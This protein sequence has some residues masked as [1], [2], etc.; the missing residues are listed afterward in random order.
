MNSILLPSN[1]VYT[2]CL[3]R[4]PQADGPGRLACQI[5]VAVPFGTISRP[6]G[7]LVDR[8]RQLMDT[9]KCRVYVYSYR[10]FSLTQD[11]C[12]VFT[13]NVFD[14]VLAYNHHSLTWHSQWLQVLFQT[15]LNGFRRFQAS[16]GIGFLNTAS[17]PL[18]LTRFVLDGF[19][20]YVVY[21]ADGRARW[22]AEP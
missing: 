18:L 9:R 14:Y 16:S 13:D 21:R 11:E 19:Y 7:M 1:L 5:H 15:K 12:S 20:M 10:P 8:C 4:G 22:W 6:C 2:H 3:V 17:F